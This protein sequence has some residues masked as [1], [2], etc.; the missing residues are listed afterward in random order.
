MAAPPASGLGSPMAD[1]TAFFQ[2]PRRGTPSPPAH[3]LP[4]WKVKLLCLL[5]CHPVRMGGPEETGRV[6]R[7]EGM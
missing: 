6:G 1:G 4:R 2:D 3:P 5:H 7:V